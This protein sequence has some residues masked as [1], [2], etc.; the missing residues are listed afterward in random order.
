[1]NKWISISNKHFHGGLVVKNLPWNAGDVG[2]I[3]GG[4][5]KIPHAAEQLN[6][7]AATTET[8]SQTRESACQYERSCMTQRTLGQN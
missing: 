1:M 4:G 7:L 5:T 6:L 8:T 2:S 3:P